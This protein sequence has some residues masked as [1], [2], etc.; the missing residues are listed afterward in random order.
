M[1]YKDSLTGRTVIIVIVI[2]LCCV[3]VTTLQTFAGKVKVHKT[4]ALPMQETE[5]CICIE[6]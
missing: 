4:G 1:W 6:C 2:G 5:V 3:S